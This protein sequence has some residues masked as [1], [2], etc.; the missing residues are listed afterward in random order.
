M[1]IRLFGES[2][3]NYLNTTICIGS[4]E[5]GKAFYALLHHLNTTICIGS[6]YL[7]RFNY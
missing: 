4:I 3:Y 1:S 6:I 7:S 2:C 5:Y